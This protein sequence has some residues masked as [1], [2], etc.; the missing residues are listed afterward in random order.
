MRILIAGSFKYDFYDEACAVAFEHLGCEVHRFK[1]QSYYGTGLKGFAQQRWLTGPGIWALNRDLLRDTT[2]VQ[3]DVVFVTRGV[4]L[5]LSTLRAIKQQTHAT[6]VSYNNDDP[7]GGVQT[8]RLWKNFIECIPGYDLHF[9]FR[10]VNVPEYYE[11][12]AKSV[13]VLLPYYVPALHY[14]ITLNDGDL[15]RFTCDI[16]FVGHAK[17]D[18]RLDFFR[19]LV[20]ENYDLRLYGLHWE[21]FVKRAPWLNGRIYPPVWGL[22]YTRAIR[23]SKVALAFFARV[24]RDT[25]TTRTFEIP[26][27]GTSM[28]SERTPD[29]M[30]FFREGIEAAYFST[31]EDLIEKANWLLHDDDARADMAYYARQRVTE[32]GASVEDRMQF[33]LDTI[34]RQKKS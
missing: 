19:A 24:N 22:D 18:G 10:S 6:L 28:L 11:Y 17:N 5:R 20:K 32:I 23:A 3:P 25:Y 14:P 31:S 4:P 1:W 2:V 12:G 16:A 29:M 21:R 8:K 7:F 13:E 15:S 33:V 9:V 27:I 34:L 26:A 30:G